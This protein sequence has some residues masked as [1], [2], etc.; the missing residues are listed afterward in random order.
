MGALQAAILSV[1]LKHL[2]RWNASRRAIAEVYWQELKNISDL[3]VPPQDPW[4]TAASGALH[5]YVVNHPRRD[6]LAAE[7]KKKG[8]ETGIHY[9]VPCHKSL[10]WKKSFAP[11][12]FPEAEKYAATCLSLPL[13]ALMRV[14][15][16]REVVSAI[17]NILK[18]R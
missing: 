4:Q 16:A 15:E 8:V 1:K 7:L 14:S 3:I 18:G 9:P 6:W 11:S 10:A 13:F 2:D 17:K 12:H 5:L